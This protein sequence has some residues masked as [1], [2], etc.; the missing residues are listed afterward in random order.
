MGQLFVS[1]LLVQNK[2]LPVVLPPL[3]GASSL[4]VGLDVFAI[5]SPLHSYFLR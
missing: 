2:T 1:L 5:G 3:T 4:A